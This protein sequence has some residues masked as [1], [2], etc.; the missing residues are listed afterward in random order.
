MLSE[1]AQFPDDRGNGVEAG[2][3]DMLERMQT[4]RWRVFKSCHDWF[5]EFRSYHRKDG[6]IVKE[7][8]DILSASRYG[9]MMLRYAQ[10][11]SDPPKRLDRYYRVR[12]KIG[13]WMSA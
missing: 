13:S 11:K 3:Q 12:K 1:R 5:E 6:K 2:I 7:R 9:L 10:P 4:G 8:E